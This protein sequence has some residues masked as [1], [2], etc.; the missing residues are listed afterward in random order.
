MKFHF[1]LM[2]TIFL[3]SCATT[4]SSKSEIT[5][6]EV[7]QLSTKNDGETYRIN[8]KSGEVWII[9]GN[10]LKVVSESNSIQLKVGRKYYIENNYS[11][12]YLGDG[13]FTAPVKDFNRLW[14]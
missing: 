14:N 5:D 10:S 4:E 11:I 7:Y 9:E 3:T 12:K 1:F 2:I 8:T 6:H 13:K